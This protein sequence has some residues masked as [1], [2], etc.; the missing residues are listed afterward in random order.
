MQN[1]RLA[2]TDKKKLQQKTGNSPDQQN[3][4]LLQI[5]ETK[6]LYKLVY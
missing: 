3:F 6:L 4:F 1:A 5:T 2:L